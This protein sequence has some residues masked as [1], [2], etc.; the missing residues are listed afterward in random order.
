MLAVSL[1][2]GCMPVTPDVRVE[3][4]GA[5]GGGA[6]LEG[7]AIELFTGTYVCMHAYMRA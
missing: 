5:S 7:S 6:C 1:S 2:L 4:G 3:R